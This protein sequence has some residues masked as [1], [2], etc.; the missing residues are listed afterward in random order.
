MYQT[1]KLS[2]SDIPTVIVETLG[3][4]NSCYFHSVLLGCNPSYQERDNV[5]YRTSLA[6]TLRNYLAEKLDSVTVEGVRIYDTLSEGN[7]KHYSD[8]IKSVDDRFT[9]SGM[10]RVLKSNSPVDHTFQELICDTLEID[11][12]LISQDT[13]DVYSVCQEKN[14]YIKN[15]PSIILCYEH[16]ESTGHYSLLGVVRENKLI[17]CFDPD[18]RIIEEIKKRLFSIQK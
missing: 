15:R 2:F 6:R 10:I 5:S 1:F 18:D 13:R 14:L 7:L 9:L 8:A 11:V 16:S 3:T 12:Y 17:T 4:E